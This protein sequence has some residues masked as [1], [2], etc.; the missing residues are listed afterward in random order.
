MCITCSFLNRVIA[1]PIAH[2]SDFEG[3]HPDDTNMYTRDLTLTFSFTKSFWKTDP[4]VDRISRWL[5]YSRNTIPN[6]FYNIRISDIADHASVKDAIESLCSGSDPAKIWVYLRLALRDWEE[7]REDE[8]EEDP[9]WMRESR[10]QQ[11]IRTEPKTAEELA[12]DAYYDDIFAEM[13]AK[14]NAEWHGE[15]KEEPEEE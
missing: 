1:H 3:P 9:A 11:G 6:V 7:R 4:P 15:V 13:D 2:L 8:T 5:R 14:Q 12:V 10:E